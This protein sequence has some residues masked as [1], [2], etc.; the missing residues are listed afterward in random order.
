MNIDFFE[1]VD[2]RDCAVSVNGEVGFFCIREC[3]EDSW[4]VFTK[5][6]RTKIASN[7]PHS[8]ILPTVMRHLGRIA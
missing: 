7:I 5:G 8:E 2:G 1:V 6:D 4:C 3:N